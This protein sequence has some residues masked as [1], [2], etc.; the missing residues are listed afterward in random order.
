MALRVPV[1]YRLKNG[2][3]KYIRHMTNQPQR[4]KPRA[5]A[6]GGERATVTA[7]TTGEDLLA[8]LSPE[9]LKA[10]REAAR[11]GPLLSLQLAL[12]LAQ[13]AKRK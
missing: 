12:L 5:I 3:A 9:H 11:L 8:A 2:R 7:V 6:D 4:E 10:C 1:S 13:R